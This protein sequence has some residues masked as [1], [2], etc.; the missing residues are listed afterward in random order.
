MNNNVSKINYLA[1]IAAVVAAA[2]VSSVWYS[3]FMLGKPWMELRDANAA[4]TAGATLPVWKIFVEIVRE[5]VV[6]YVLARFVNRTGITD[7]KGALSLG[8]W[9]W[10]GFPVAMLVGAS[11]WDNK[12]WTL[13]CIHAGDWFIKMLLMA[14]ILS[15]WPRVQ[16]ADIRTSL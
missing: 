16:I 11:L 12:P 2:V 10:L 15:K 4:A 14:V 9:V 13:T 8:F 1:V 3:P 6:A 5:F 7:W